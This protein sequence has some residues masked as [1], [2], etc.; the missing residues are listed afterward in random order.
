MKQSFGE[1]GQWHAD[2]SARHFVF[3]SVDGRHADA[4]QRTQDALM[5]SMPPEDR[6]AFSEFCQQLTA[7]PE[8]RQAIEFRV[9][10]NNGQWRW[11]EMQG[12]SAADAS[13]TPMA[14]GIFSDCSERKQVVE[15][16]SEAVRR[17]QQFMSATSHDIQG[18][19]RL[20]SMFASI[21]ASD[22]GATATPQQKEML[23]AIEKKGAELK[24]RVQTVMGFSAKTKTPKRDTVS[25]DAVVERAIREMSAD[26]EKAQGAV[27]AHSLPKAIGDEELLIFVFV[28]LI[29]NA[30]LHRV[31]APPTIIV[32]GERSQGGI[33]VHV[34]DDGPGIAPDDTQRVFDPYWS[35]PSGGRPRRPGLGLTLCKT[36]L[37][38]L[39][40]DIEVSK[41]GDAGTVMT[42]SLPVTNMVS[43]G[44]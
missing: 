2:L 5:E 24:T 9:R 37:L 29:E 33:K 23:D 22:L 42:I 10:D 41:T 31:D 20:M 26:I 34:K 19:L 27:E 17:M 35:R 13:G 39:D 38:A 43:P 3:K 25:L 30:L 4:E 7:A 28:N 18:P 15:R 16:Q 1:F 11:F 44:Q 8:K 12:A 32:K 36:I 6:L 14:R 40:G 21:L